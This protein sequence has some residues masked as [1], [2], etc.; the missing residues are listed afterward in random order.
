MN[1]CI[2]RFSAFLLLSLVLSNSGENPHNLAKPLNPITSRIFSVIPELNLVIWDAFSY[3][4]VSLGIRLI[5]GGACKVSRHLGGYQVFGLQPHSV[6][7]CDCFQVYLQS[8]CLSFWLLL[9]CATLSDHG[10]VI[11]VNRDLR[12]FSCPPQQGS[13]PPNLCEHVAFPGHKTSTK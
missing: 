7:F 11:I 5:R 10:G 2:F 8:W 4:W 12:M 9:R 6:Y 13:P 3:L 1:Y